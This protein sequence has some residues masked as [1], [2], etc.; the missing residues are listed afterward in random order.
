M[1]TSKKITELDELTSANTSDL[2]YIVHDPANI[3]VS[4]KITVDNLF[5]SVNL[6]S[7]NA[8][9]IYQTTIYTD[10]LVA[11]SYNASIT[12]A[13]NLVSNAYNAAVTFATNVAAN[14]Y[15]GATTFASSAAANAFANAVSAI[16]NSSSIAYTNALA[17][18]ALYTNDKAANAY[19]NAVAYADSLLGGGG[20][21]SVNFDPY[22]NDA[23]GQIFL[24]STYYAEG[25]DEGSADFVDDNVALTRAN[26]YG[27]FNA[28]VDF[29]SPA[30]T[31]WNSDGFTTLTNVSA[32]KFVTFFAAANGK[33]GVNVLA[34]NFIMHDTINDKYYKIVFSVWQQGGG[35]NFSYTRQQIDGT[36]GADI[37]SLVTFAK[38]APGQGD[39][40]DTGL[41]ITRAANQGI[42]NSESEM[43]WNNTQPD[44][45]T[46]T[47]WNSEGWQD[48]SNVKLR[49][50][51]TLLEVSS[52]FGYMAG[53]ELVMHDTSND[54]YY[55]FKFSNWQAGANGGAFSYERKLI[56]TGV[57]F[58]RQDGSNSSVM[59]VA[60]EIAPGL[61]ITRANGG[62]IYNSESEG[63]SNWDTSP[64]GTLWNSDGWDDLT[65]IT[66]R[67]YTTLASS[68]KSATG[69]II[70]NSDY[71]MWDTINDEYWTVKF[72]RWQVGNN[73]GGYNYPGF[74]YIRRKLKNSQQASGITFADGSIQTSAVTKR[75][76]GVV[77]QKRVT[78]ARRYLHVD[79][80]GKQLYVDDANNVWIGIPD[81]S[82]AQFP[83][84]ATIT[85]V[86]RSGLPLY[87][88]KL[89]DDETGNLFISGTTVNTSSWTVPDHG[90]G[91]VV[92]LVKTKDE[93][94][95]GANDRRVEWTLTTDSLLYLDV[96][97][98]SIDHAG[99]GKI[100]TFG[101]TDNQTIITAAA[102]KSGSPNAQ[103]LVIQ[104][105]KGY[106][107][108]EGGDIYLWAG[109]SG[110]T[111]GS[112]GDIKA[113]AGNG[114]NGS[115]GGTIKIRGGGSDTGTGGF[116][117]IW[118]G[119]GSNGANITLS[120]W[121][122][123]G[124]S[125]WTYLPSGSLRTP[126]GGELSSSSD[127]FYI[128]PS[129]YFDN[130]LAVYPT[131]DY[132]IHLFEAATN[133]AVTIGNYGQSF[134]RVYG[135]GGSDNAGANGQEIAIHTIN[136][137]NIYFQTNSG[138][139]TWTLTQNG[140]MF[141]ANS[142]SFGQN[143]AHIPS[144]ADRTGE[145]VT[146]WDQLGSYYSYSIGIEADNMW[147]GVDES[148]AT[149][150]GFKWYKGNTEVMKLSRAGKLN[151]LGDTDVGGNLFVNGAMTVTGGITTVAAN[152]LAV[153]ANFIYL[154]DTDNELNLDLGI[155]GN[156]NDGTYRHTGIFR[157]A[158]DGYWKV[159]DNY[160]PEP[161]A[162][163]N[164]DT[165]NS[166][167]HVANFHA[168]TMR[169]GNT[170]VYATINSTSYSGLVDTANSAN[171]LYGNSITVTA[172]GGGMTFNAN[173]SGNSRPGYYPDVSNVYVFNI[174]NSTYSDTLMSLGATTDAVGGKITNVSA[175]E[176]NR[177]IDFG[178]GLGDNAASW[179]AA[180]RSGYISGFSGYTYN[181]PE[182][183]N[184]YGGGHL[185]IT[186]GY[187]TGN[188]TYPNQDG[189]SVYIYSGDGASEGGNT[190]TIEII[191][192]TAVNTF[193]SG[194]I[195]IRTGTSDAN[196]GTVS[197]SG[198]AGNA[199]GG[200]VVISG[201]NTFVGV[202][203]SVIIQSGLWN[204]MTPQGNVSIT[205]GNVTINAV[206]LINT[207]SSSGN[208]NITAQ[209][210]YFNINSFYGSINS[211]SFTG[212]ANNATYI[213]ANNGVVSNTSGVFAKQSNGITV[214]SSGIL[215]KANNGVVSN[216][217][218]VFV[219]ANT[220]LVVNSTGLFVN[221]TYIGTL[222]AN[223]TS[224]V[225]TV[226]AANV[227][228][229]S[230][231][232]SNLANYALL[233]GATFTNNISVANTLTVTKLA[234]LGS[235]TESFVSYANANGLFTF[236]CSN[237][238]IFYLTTPQAAFTPSLS[239][240]TLA[241][242][243]VSAVSFVINQGGTP[244]ITTSNVQIG[245]ANST[246][247]WQSGLTPS[248]TASK[249]DVVTLSIFNSSG[250]YL[251]L[252]QL[253]SFG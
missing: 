106:D 153:T 180:Y 89:N 13:N 152:S 243:T 151:V 107:N 99:T 241:N 76:A 176:V 80:I 246:I 88:E 1:A 172:L 231:L 35:G 113:D 136:A 232:S 92:K 60:D 111:G 146:L 11:N 71:V 190:G 199:Y 192:A 242:N 121:N 227:V 187:G 43:G 179:P 81:S 166:T 22:T 218:G 50:Y 248:G 148:M 61:T 120:T 173:T 45:P 237:S 135:S 30:G 98:G 82:K 18:A 220:G 137:A 170:T 174:G 185:V 208:V 214:D 73:N 228:S 229:N 221:S 83:L 101:D 103:R 129:Q 169:I 48:L 20:G 188:T 196:A 59:A 127:R 198:G 134:V 209:N 49:N 2:L 239:N 130:K 19:A 128:K 21:L 28:L 165:T 52:R 38:T 14:A 56:N 36:T 163:L 212:T 108:G 202:P 201:G 149:T 200:N 183:Q 143:Q 216:S 182:T 17:A 184:A 47:E 67:Q 203:G 245:G 85:I 87:I 253:T 123:S 175:I 189:G 191:T 77:E 178:Y 118:S 235:I 122:G 157:D 211:T 105:Q 142:I 32:R 102:P 150:D 15:N 8:S 236:D 114:Y 109:H 39:A 144:L 223:N 215:V 164:I 31:L 205:G 138:S 91:E 62:F 161:D 251:V 222:T 112:G 124:W 64:A 74:S 41:T 78:T 213:N 55:T 126:I 96:G 66:T 141:M 177:S 7:F 63:S 53:Q 95:S 25:P 244:Y 90:G 24:S 252:G 155:A 249:K 115:D 5:K 238:T 86:N 75:D 44:S 29:P 250:T 240:F 12:Y 171:N 194:D 116:V 94:D 193:V 37:G 132:D 23:N 110:D 139:H 162:A 97:Q 224:F 68:F 33:L 58:N 233:S 72:T 117:E 160:E 206:G 79:D 65:D 145:K 51:S 46:N 247:N 69:E 9:V 16:T 125:Q 54:K 70:L 219:N 100:F 93:W 168:N 42:Y 167:F 226:S 57:F 27:L 158:S 204:S 186:G 154:N 147:F 104:G 159:F 26:Q 34:K 3:P 10:T 4:K 230:Q 133:G 234:A 84:G 195:V 140:T 156:Y 181:L 207:Y 217:T 6:A 119:S 225:G 131:A 197:I 40:I 210:G